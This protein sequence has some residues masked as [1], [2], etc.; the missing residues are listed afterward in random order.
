ML[1]RIACRSMNLPLDEASNLK[2]WII[3]L[4]ARPV[5]MNEPRGQNAS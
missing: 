1:N 2:I 5:S 4:G 3:T